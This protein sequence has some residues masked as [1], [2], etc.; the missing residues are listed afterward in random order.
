MMM[1]WLMWGVYTCVGVY[2]AI[3]VFLFWILVHVY[4]GGVISWGIF[5]ICVQF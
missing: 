4:M 1:R 5:G 3:V 2:I